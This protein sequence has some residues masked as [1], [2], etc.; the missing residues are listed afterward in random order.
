MNTTSFMNCTL[1]DLHM[2]EVLRTSGAVFL[3]LTIGDFTRDVDVDRACRSALE[4][5]T[6]YFKC[7]AAK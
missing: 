5:A 3:P 6:L 1:A 2:P 4:V 7:G